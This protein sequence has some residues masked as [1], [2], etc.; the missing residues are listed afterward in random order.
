MAMLKKGDFLQ[1]ATIGK[2]RRVYWITEVRESSNSPGIFFAVSLH[3][4][5][6]GVLSMQEK[7]FL[8]EEGEEAPSGYRQI[9]PDI[10][11][12]EGWE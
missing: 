6:D 7:V 1:T 2:Q 12:W 4:K 10:H 8:I 11:A 5:R 9:D 3:V